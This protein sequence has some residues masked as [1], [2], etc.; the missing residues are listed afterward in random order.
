MIAPTCNIDIVGE[1]IASLQR[2][3]A[4]HCRYSRGRRLTNVGSIREATRGQDAV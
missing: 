1:D 3:D 2:L 4:Y